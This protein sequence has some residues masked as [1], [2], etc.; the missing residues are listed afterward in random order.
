MPAICRYFGSTKCSNCEQLVPGW[1]R[2]DDAQRGFHG[3]S[4][5]AAPEI[6]VDNKH[7]EVRR[8]IRERL[9]RS[10]VESLRR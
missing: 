9:Q 1:R 2:A 7:S 4:A 8:G 5:H 6:V 10:V 3:R